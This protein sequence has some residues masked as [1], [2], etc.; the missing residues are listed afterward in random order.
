MRRFAFACIA[1]LAL[2]AVPPRASAAEQTTV[3][4]SPAPVATPS[5]RGYK[6]VP[7]PKII[8]PVTLPEGLGASDP[9]PTLIQRG[10]DVEKATY[11]TLP[12]LKAPIVVPP[13]G[14]VERAAQLVGV[15]ATPFVGITLADAVAMALVRNTNLAVSQA[16]RRIARYQIVSDKGAYDVNFG[17]SPSYE[18]TVTPANSPLETGPDGGPITQDIL[19]ATA[20]FSGL[21]PV[22]GGR[23]TLTF[24]GQ[25]VTTDYAATG[26]DPYY[27]T[28]ATLGIDQPLL[29]NR[30]ID[31]T[32]RQLLTDRIMLD[33]DSDAA[34]VQAQSV[35][36]NVANAYWDL[37]YA[38][39]NVAVREAALRQAQLQ[40][41]SNARRVRLARAAASDV[42]EAN[43]QVSAYQGE[44]SLAMQ[45]VQQEQLG[46]K[47]LILADTRDPIWT[48]NLVPTTPTEN[49]VAEPDVDRAI[50]L[51]LQHRPELTQ[52]SDQRRAA[53]VQIAY[54]RDQ[55]KPQLDLGAA[56][57]PQGI[58]GVPTAAMQDPLLFTIQQQTTAIDQLIAA[59]NAGLP[60]G[61]Q[62]VPLPMQNYNISAAENGSFGSSAKSLVSG[63]YPSYYL[64]LNF[65]VPIGNHTA[66]GAF[67]VAVEQDRELQVQQ[68]AVVLSIKSGAEQA[69]QMLRADAA[70]LASARDQRQA[71]QAV[72][73][74]ELRRR[75]VGKSTTFLVLQRLAA[76]V[77]ARGDELQAQS[78][79]SKALAYYREVTGELLTETGVDVHTLGTKTLD[80]TTGPPPSTKVPNP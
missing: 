60:A 62:I 5:P 66:R 14:T 80:A 10:A 43:A 75:A 9:G 4:P 28:S 29:R 30:N 79:Y 70:V 8:A 42:A 45:S 3:A 69:V 25:R 72:Y 47:A 50:V 74:S 27:P 55:L 65:M 2:Q 48:A 56:I 17:L 22:G 78:N 59:A 54:A 61:S 23:Y 1:S 52:I 19:G 18:H 41:E 49:V 44:V 20:S 31:A 40:A 46:L 64:Q 15:L 68:F 32:R 33:V 36:V 16:N 71:R 12:S 57:R 63:R 76:L 73:L 24:Q 7:V 53:N 67:D 6:A 34:L 38:W 13:A 37:A 26:F 11:P 58:G 35:I 39:Q 77:S 21:F 51:A